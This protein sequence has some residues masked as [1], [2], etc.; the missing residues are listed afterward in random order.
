MPAMARI[1]AT[2]MLP[3]PA[4]DRLRA[5]H[6]VVEWPGALPP[7]PEELLAHARGADA[8]LTLVTDPVDAALAQRLD[9]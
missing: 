3:F 5:E 9:H 7:T 8:L 1:F 2:R 4:L 6:E